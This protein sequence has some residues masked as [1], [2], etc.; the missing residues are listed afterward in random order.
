MSE[1]KQALVLAVA[2][3]QEV[4][5]AAKKLKKEGKEGEKKTSAERA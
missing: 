1:E 5:E 2:R 3:M 4:L